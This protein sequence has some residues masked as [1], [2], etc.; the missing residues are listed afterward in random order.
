[1]G[2]P[3]GARR[4]RQARPP[5]RCV[6]GWQILHSAGIDAAPRRAGPTWKQFVTA[7]A[8][9]MI[10]VDLVHLDTV[11][12]RRL[13]ALIVIEHATRRVYLADITANP[14]GAWTARAAR[15]FLMAAAA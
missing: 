14:D 3:A 1:V 4:A 10:A 6:H 12:L 15:N 5:D 11:L 7:Q 8:R 2:A 13:Y 9:G